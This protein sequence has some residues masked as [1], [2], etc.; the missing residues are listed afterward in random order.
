MFYGA[1]PKKIPLKAIIDIETFV[2]DTMSGYER[3]KKYVY[4][5][6]PTSDGV[7]RFIVNRADPITFKSIS[8]M[9]GRDRSNVYFK[10]HVIK[11]ADVNSFQVL[12][13][14][15]SAKD[16]KNIYYLGEKVK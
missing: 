4:Y 14:Q 15:D 7:Y 2:A 16:K 6:R 9:Y 11:S 13:D 1:Y 10:S 3:D 12:S 8:K 5:A